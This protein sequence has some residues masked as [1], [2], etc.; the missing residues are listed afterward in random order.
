MRFVRD[1]YEVLGVSPSAS[2]EEIRRAHRVRAVYDHRHGVLGVKAEL[3]KLHEAYETLTDAE[4]R[5]TFDRLRNAFLVEPRRESVAEQ[6]A[7]LR[8]EGRLRRAYAHKVATDARRMSERCVA[9]SDDLVQ[10]LT[11]ASATS[12][13]DRSRG[14][15]QL[16]VLGFCLALACGLALLYLLQRS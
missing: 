13:P 3:S 15:R 4:S 11:S 14:W 2:L 1:H 10:E 12:A 8:R 16:S 5:R 6:S 7:K 9:R